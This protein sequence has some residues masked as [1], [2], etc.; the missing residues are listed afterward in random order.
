MRAI[1]NWL[2]F[3]AFVF[4]AFSR[5]A[6]A[7]PQIIAL[8]PN[9]AGVPF[10]CA[11]GQCQ[12]ELSSYCL[13]RGRPIPRRGKVYNPVALA[14]F[15]LLVRG[16]GGTRAVPATEALKFAGKREF[17]SMAATI[18]ADALRAL[19]GGETE[20]VALRVRPGATLLPEPV[21]LDPFPLTEKEIAYVRDWRRKQAAEI[22]DTAP[23]ARTV[24]TLAQFL[25]LLP[26][27]GMG[28]PAA[29]TATWR[30]AI[31]R[32]FK[33]GA[34][35]AAMAEV[36]TEL[37]RCD[38]SGTRYSYMGLRRCMEFRH[39]DLIRD[40]NIEYWVATQPGS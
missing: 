15:E 30:D 2:V 7:A 33:D 13:Q 26:A 12:A 11:D 5:P 9:E 36:E 8:L 14:D 38:S 27:A 16:P 19:A 35:D 20:I 4:I 32:E 23:G 6:Q 39:D 21:A 40:L 3:T 29:V 34:S 24:R 1:R 18:D 25:N 17:M 28:D 22:V 37:E 10:T 31:R